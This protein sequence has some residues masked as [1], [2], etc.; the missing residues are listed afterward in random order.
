MFSNSY[1]Y[2]HSLKEDSSRKGS[3]P[4]HQQNLDKKYNIYMHKLED[5]SKG[6]TNSIKSDGTKRSFP[7][8]SYE[9]QMFN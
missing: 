7:E 3:L 2:P 6:I 5:F 8:D 1:V 9:A 4:I